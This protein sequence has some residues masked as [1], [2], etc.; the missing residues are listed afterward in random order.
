MVIAFANAIGG[1]MPACEALSDAGVLLAEPCLEFGDTAAV[2]VCGGF[3][4]LPWRGPWLRAQAAGLA[5][6]P[7]AEAVAAGAYRQAV[8][9]LQKGRAATM[10]DVARAWELLPLGGR[11]LICGDNDLGIATFVKRLGD[12]LG[13]AGEVVAN[14]GHGRIVVFI[15]SEKPLPSEAVDQAVPLLPNELREPGMDAQLLVS[16]GVFSAGSLDEGTAALINCLA[17]Q[18]PPERVIDLGCGAGHLGIAALVRWP[19]CTVVFADHDRRAVR[20]VRANLER[21]GLSERAT[22]VWWDA[23]EPAPA[24]GCDLALVNPPF[25]DG[26]AVDLSPAKAMFRAVDEALGRDGRAL[27]VANRTLPYE[28]DLEPLGRVKLARQDS[29]FKVIEV[30]RG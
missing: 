2:Q 6:A 16:P 4:V 20:C 25:H 11:L 19:R 26:T 13:D 24:S 1:S 30:A 28:R 23:E 12:S 22:V 9:H 21:L 29:R 17:L 8:V 3:V 27:V 7:D 15:R 5:A 18:P 14:R 10:A